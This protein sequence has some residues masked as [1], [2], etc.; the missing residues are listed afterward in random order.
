MFGG[1][2]QVSI[3]F[4]G[5]G[6]VAFVMDLGRSV[7]LDDVEQGHRRF[8]RLCERGRNRQGR[9]GQF[10]TVQGD[11]QVFEHRFISQRMSDRVGRS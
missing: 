6:Q 10:R 7:L 2:C 3:R 11:K 5:V 1:F 9:F 8:E 4:P